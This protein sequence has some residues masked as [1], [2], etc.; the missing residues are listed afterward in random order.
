MRHDLFSPETAALH[1]RLT[2]KLHERLREMNDC[3]EEAESAIA[4]AHEARL[5]YND[6]ALM[7]ADF[8]KA[9]LVDLREASEVDKRVI[10][11]ALHR[12]EGFR[13]EHD[14]VIDESEL[15]EVEAVAHAG[16]SAFESLPLTYDADG[17]PYGGDGSVA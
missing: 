3:L 10:E 12:Y 5:R 4:K 2:Q 13:R 6:A 15:P 11:Y 16:P 9:R 7:A 17:V 14:L 1:A 8:V